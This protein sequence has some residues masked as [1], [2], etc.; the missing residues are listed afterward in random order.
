MTSSI[1]RMA[2][3]SELNYQVEFSDEIPIMAADEAAAA[4]VPPHDDDDGNMSDKSSAESSMGSEEGMESTPYYLSAATYQ[5]Y[6]NNAKF[7]VPA[8][9]IRKSPQ[10][11]KGLRRR[12]SSP[13]PEN[14][15]AARLL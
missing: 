5:D 3:K 15:Q 7:K 2:N 6:Q 13:D 9:R 14:R 12:T 1:A 10:R 4:A 11:A 8:I